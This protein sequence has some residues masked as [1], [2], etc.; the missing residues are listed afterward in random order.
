M[1]VFLDSV[2]CRLNQ[3]EIEIIAGQLRLA[4]HTLVPT[5]A[6]SDLVILNTCAVTS[7]AASDSRSKTRRAHRRSPSGKIILTGCWST[8]EPEKAA[9]LPG[10]ARVVPN[11]DKGQ[12]VSDLFGIPQ[13][14]FEL[15]PL[16]RI[17]IPGLRMRTRAFIKAQD[18][19][20]NHCTFCLTR[21][22]RGPSRSV[23]ARQILQDVKNALAG[24]AKEVVLT[25]VQLS[26]YG[27]DLDDGDDLLS[28][29]ELILKETTVPRLRLSS[30]EPWGLPAGFFELW[31]DP[32]MCRQLHLPLQSGS[33]SV[34]RRMARPLLPN[35]YANQVE[36]ARGQIPGLALTTD[37]IVGFPGESEKEFSESFAFI[38]EMNFADAHVFTY[39]SR[40]N[41]AANRLPNP[42][43]QAVARERSQIVRQQVSES[44]TAYA[45]S[46]VGKRLVALWENSSGLDDEGWEVKGLTDNYLRVKSTVPRD[47]W[48]ELTPIRV[49]KREGDELL[50]VPL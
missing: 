11:E 4:G 5:A 7:S 46:F 39:S 1:K 19:C 23:D 50:V 25:G 20:D 2:G 10:V 21:V 13:E 31:D 29:V 30:L 27:K 17:P 35:Q 34:L 18:G 43:P 36:Q 48:N 28:L 16:Q 24:G 40:P 33:A 42:V 38:Q 44:S 22:A 6:E 41:T 49:E 15:E 3:S 32:R 47:L 14:V 45:D 9:H 8:L 26:A 37:I 12:L